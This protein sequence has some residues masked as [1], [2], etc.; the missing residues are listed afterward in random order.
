MRI[1]FIVTS[2]PTLS[3]TF[4]LNQI[5]GLLDRGHEIDIYAERFGDLKR[6]H[7]DVERYR[8]L[9]RTHCPRM[10]RNLLLRMLKG[11][12]LLVTE[13]WKKHPAP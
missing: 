8:L 4:I 10:P 9:A 5:T 3:T 12:G 11:P 1:A 2:F 6:K 13:G 7:P